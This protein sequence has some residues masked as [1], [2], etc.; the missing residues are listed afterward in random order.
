MEEIRPKLYGRRLTS[1]LVVA[2]GLWCGGS[3]AEAP[4][5]QTA[6]CPASLDW[7]SAAEI[8][9]G[10]K[11][12]HLTL[13]EP[14]LMENY[15]VRI[16]LHTPGLRVTSSGRASNW[17]EPMPDYTNSVILIDVKRQ[18]TREFLYEH[19][20]HGTNMV[21][22]LNTSPWGPWCPPFT[23]A[24]GRFASLTVSDGRRVS[25]SERRNGMLVIYTNNVAVIRNDLE[26]ARIPSVAI[27]HPGHGAGIIMKGGTPLAPHNSK[28]K[29]WRGLAPRTAFGI[30]AD[31]RWLYGV[32]VDG[33]QPGYSLGADMYDLVRILKAAGAM[34]AINMDGGGSATLVWWDEQKKSPVVPNHH[35]F[36]SYRPVAMSLGFYFNE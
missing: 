6:T 3:L 26:D 20:T 9:R 21:L 17:G 32:V 8:G 19:R 27:A 13:T 1:V 2:V 24:Y 23:H 25:R 28:S 7:E 16:D 4:A 22:A 11:Y 14:R 36:W 33:R 15:L 30:S 35:H 31:G 5:L 12:I 10:M 29:A 34:D 18:R